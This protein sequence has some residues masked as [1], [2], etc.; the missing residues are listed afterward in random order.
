M[1]IKKLL[2]KHKWIKETEK[3]TTSFYPYSCVYISICRCE[4]CG[5]KL[6]R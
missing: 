6:K 5:K 3:V 4:K 1:N 2:C